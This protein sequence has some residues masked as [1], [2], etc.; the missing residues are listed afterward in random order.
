MHNEFRKVGTESVTLYKG[1]Y[2]FE[3][4]G[5]SGGEG[6]GDGTHAPGGKGGY[7]KGYITLKKKSHF[8]IKIGGEGSANGRNVVQEGGFNGGGKGGTAYYDSNYL[9]AGGGGGGASDI[10]YNGDGIADRI[11]V[12]G[13]GGGGGG[14]GFT[15]E[16][17]GFGGG[18]NGEDS[19]KYFMKGGIQNDG[20]QKGVG[21]DG[22]SSDR[23]IDHGSCGAGG[24]GGG[25]WGGRAQT[26]NGQQTQSG[27]G[28]GSGFISGLFGCISKDITFY[29]GLLLGG[30]ETF[31][32][33]NDENE[34][35]H[36][37]NGA[38]RITILEISTPAYTE[39]RSLSILTFLSILY[40]KC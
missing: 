23:I 3:C 35:G 1:R 12:A 36:S 31:K 21:G 37:G 26:S 27:G 20:F 2:I 13:G 40:S 8:T 33:I 4:W 10:R 32:N 7:A 28:G 15:Y 17:G 25:Y 11:I 24:G 39:I 18:L 34:K 19:G 14:G 29:D 30:N 38:V 16:Y 6:G 9:F 22:R 5:A